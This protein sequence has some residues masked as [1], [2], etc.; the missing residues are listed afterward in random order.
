MSS[1]R[2][3]V[4]AKP[5]FFEDLDRQLRPERGPHGEPSTND[6]QALEL[7]RI[8]EKFATGFETLPE[9]IPGRP[10]YRILIA[11]GTLVPMFAVVGQL[12]QDGAVELIS[13]DI[14][15]GPLAEADG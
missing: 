14:D 9:L 12:A 1:E 13:L 10:D 7:L 6:F 11:T 5:E 2:R 4:R 8:V 3:S 15:N